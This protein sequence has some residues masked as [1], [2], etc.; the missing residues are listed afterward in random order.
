MPTVWTYGLLSVIVPK[1]VQSSRWE[2][3]KFLP[4]EFSMASINFSL[5]SK[6]QKRRQ[7]PYSN[8]NLFTGSRATHPSLHLGKEDAINKAP[9]TF[10]APKL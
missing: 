1:M 5:P 10:L 2:D 6:G 4:D 9:P 8:S 7:I 3:W